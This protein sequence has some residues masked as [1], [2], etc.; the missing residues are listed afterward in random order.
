MRTPPSRPPRAHRRSS[1]GTDWPTSTVDDL[2]APSPPAADALAADR[3]ATRQARERAREWARPRLHEARR[4]VTEV[5][6]ELTELRDRTSERENEL[7][8]LRAGHE[9]T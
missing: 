4:K 5:E 7:G 6:Q 3:S 1:R 2:F 8:E 9:H